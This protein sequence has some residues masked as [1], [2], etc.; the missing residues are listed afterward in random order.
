MLSSQIIVVMGIW[1]YFSHTLRVLNSKPNSCYLL[2]Q[3][4]HMVPHHTFGQFSKYFSNCLPIIDFF[5][6]PI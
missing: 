5:C 6:Y 1:K 2:A 4:I 3:E